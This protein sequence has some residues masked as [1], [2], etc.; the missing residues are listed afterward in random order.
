MPETRHTQQR[1]EAWKRREIC[2]L[3]TLIG[4]EH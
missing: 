1:M 2:N 4:Y 3:V